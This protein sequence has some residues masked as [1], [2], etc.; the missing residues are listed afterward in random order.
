MSR[1]AYNG[2]DKWKKKA[3]E[4]LNQGGGGGTTD[5]D[6]LDNKPTLNGVTIQGSMDETDPT[7]PAWAKTPNKPSYSAAE[8]GALPDNTPIPEKTS[9]LINDSGFIND[10][11]NNLLNYYL[12]SDTYTRAEVDALISAIVTIN[13]EVVQVL[14]SQNISRTTVYLVPKA[15]AQ[16]DNIYDEYINIDGTAQ[17]W[18]KIGDTTIDLSNYYTKSEVDAKLG[19]KQATIT[20]GATS[21]VS[22]NLTAS[23]ALVS[24]SSGKVAVSAVKSTELGYLDGARANIQTQL[25]A[26]MSSS[27][28]YIEMKG[29][30]SHGGYIDFHYGQ[31][32]ADYTTRIMEGSDN[33]VITSSSRRIDLRVGASQN[34]RVQSND[35]TAWRP[36]TASAF[37]VGSSRLIKENIQELSND[38][39]KKLLKVNIVAFDYKE[40][41]GGQKNQRGVIAEDV[42]DVIPYVVDVPE[43][44]QEDNFN[45]ELGTNQDMLSVDYSKFIPYLIKMIQFQQKE[46]DEL[47]SL[48]KGGSQ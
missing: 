25:D 12:K 26:K 31:S 17:G 10:T 43:G 37:T 44:Y 3:T 45:E 7:V 39:A 48:I 6:E 19:T 9:D 16:T 2:A 15:T 40:N 28:T 46:I 4:L 30:T 20:G 24:N 35:T 22:S 36:I 18:E 11:V 34:V 41:F 13:I 42:L 8:V 5:Y 27:P 1:I 47:K 29:S 32:T 14:P 23:R 38:E 21:I 33:L